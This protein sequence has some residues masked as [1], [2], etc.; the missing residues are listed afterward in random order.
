[1]YLDCNSYDS[2]WHVPSVLLVIFLLPSPLPSPPSLLSSLLSVL[3]AN[4]ESSGILGKETL[5]LLVNETQSVVK[6]DEVPCLEV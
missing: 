5:I 4:L 2:L 3:R 1:M 6:Y